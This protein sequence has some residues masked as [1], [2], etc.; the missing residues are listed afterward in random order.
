MIITSL[1][2]Q[3]IKDI[4]KLKNIKQVKKNKKFLIEGLHLIEEAIKKNNVE[5]IFI[6]ESF[7]KN[8]FLDNN[9]KINYISENI[10]KSLSD[11]VNNQ[12]IFAV[13]NIIEK[14]LNIEKYSNIIA[15]DA[16]Q[17]PGN[18]GTIIRT[19]DAFDFDCILL[20]KGTT[21]M[22][23]QKVIR[24]MQGSNFH[25]DCYDNI[26]LCEVLKKADNHKIFA[27][28]L[29]NSDYLENT[30]I[31][32]TENNIIIFGNEANGISNDLIK[33]A[34]KLIKINMPGEAESLNV[35]VSAGIVMHYFKNIIK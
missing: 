6:S 1:N 3:K 15:L 29:N 5:E 21:S 2:N 12:G 23:S 31:N 9:I 18:L 17:D 35:S 22:Y 34:N 13:C 14:K 26:D 16:I 30:N 11:T 32:S 27:T 33:L 8:L 24:S 19:A 10:S 28:S 7:N 20:G 4:I 25:I